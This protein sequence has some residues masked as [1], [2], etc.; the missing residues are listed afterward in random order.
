MLSDADYNGQP[1]KVDVDIQPLD[2]LEGHWDRWHA[3]SREGR[4]GRRKRNVRVSVSRRR[5][6]YKTDVR[7]MWSN[8]KFW[9]VEWN[10][11]DRMRHCGRDKAQGDRQ[12]WR[13]IISLIDLFTRKR[14]DRRS[15][16]WAKDRSLATGQANW[17][18]ERKSRKI[19]RKSTAR[20]THTIV[21]QLDLTLFLQK[22][23][24]H[25]LFCTIW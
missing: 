16:L 19:K 21:I 23:W 24:G 1:A 9:N 3:C 8:D 12:A 17:K 18:S 22:V 15:W 13:V 11:K 7:K 20:Q 25:V 6:T 4:Q 5:E 14:A 2:W 10:K